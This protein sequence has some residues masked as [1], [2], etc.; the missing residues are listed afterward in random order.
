MR[1]KWLLGSMLVLLAACEVHVGGDPATPANPA[2]GAAPAPAPAPAAVATNAPGTGAPAA[3]T[4]PR[5]SVTNIGTKLGGG[6]GAAPAS[7]GTTAAAPAISG[8]IAFG[9]G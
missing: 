2:P 6:G 4:G 9:H 7:G 8:T 1:A 3:P 5:R